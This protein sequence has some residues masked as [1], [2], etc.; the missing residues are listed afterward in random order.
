MDDLPI[1]AHIAV[2]KMQLELAFGHA[3]CLALGGGA[4]FRVHHV[5]HAPANDL[6]G[7]IAKDSLECRTDIHDG[8]VGLDDAHGVEEQ[9]HDVRGARVFIAETKNS[10]RPDEKQA[11]GAVGCE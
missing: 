4:I 8:T 11:W 2:L 1:L 9:V 3:F 10:G 6:F 5:Q 7:G